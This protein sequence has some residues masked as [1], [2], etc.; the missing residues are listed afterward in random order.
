VEQ[1]AHRSDGLT[2]KAVVVRPNDARAHPVVLFAHGG[3]S[4]LGFTNWNAPAGAC[5]MCDLLKAL[6]SAGY[7]V[8]ASSYRGEDGSGGSVEV[9]QGEVDDVANLACAVAQQPWADGRFAAYGVS[10]GACVALRLA[11]RDPNLRAA[12]AFVPPMDWGT[13]YDGWQQQLARGSPLC[14]ADTARGTNA[15]SC[16]AAYVHLSSEIRG[17][18]GGTPAT[19][20]AAYAA[21]SPVGSLPLR[22]PAIL[23]HGT[24]DYVVDLGQACTARRALAGRAE[25]FQA[26]YLD[27]RGR[28]V[29]D[30]GSPPVCGG[31]FESS[32]PPI[33]GSTW[34]AGT[35][36]FLLEGEDHDVLASPLGTAGH[37]ARAAAYQFLMAKMPP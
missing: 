3:F 2:V 22:A 13:L 30:P 36:Q 35:L 9:C 21:R 12:I 5:S 20:P 27:R 11:E 32:P 15:T 17:A 4:G 37:Q 10:H 34:P 7:A 8:A 14:L 29:A 24:Q 28:P 33:G 19:Q 6:A 23:F 31:G 25:P 1:V 16:A 26:W 18:L